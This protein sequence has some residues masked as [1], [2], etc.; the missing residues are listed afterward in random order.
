MTTSPLKADILLRPVGVSSVPTTEV[1]AA[2]AG[3][4]SPEC[5]GNTARVS[6]RTRDYYRNAHRIDDLR[7]SAD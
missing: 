1:A 4:R 7:T 5:G 2:L 6:Y 3:G